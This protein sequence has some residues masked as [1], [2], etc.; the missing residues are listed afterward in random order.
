MNRSKL[1]KRLIELRKHNYQDLDEIELST[2]TNA[3]LKHIGDPD[4]K[5]RDTLIYNS[6]TY[7]IVHD[8]YSDDDLK[9][10][11]E[12]VLT[13]DYL[14]YGLGEKG[15]NSVFTRSFSTLLIALILHVNLKR[16][17]LS[18]NEL[19][20]LSN[21]LLV[22]LERE[23]DVRGL[24]EGSGW[25][26]SIA[27]VADA[28]DELA[29]QQDLTSKELETLLVAIMDKMSFNE[30]YF[31]FE[32]NERMAIPTMT[33]LSRGSD[34]KVLINRIEEVSKDL[35]TNFSSDERSQLIC[36]YCEAI[37]TGF[38][39]SIRSCRAKPRA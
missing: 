9:G 21:L 8:Y 19:R 38:V 28:I 17:F 30:D 23:V 33:I 35:Y 24:I 16:K 2:L 20:R 36:R 37:F 11:L 39:F 3:M 29:K 4:S 1:K 10:L 25:A 18:I 27:H 13:K 5:L 12:N 15:D 22:Y 32:E 6:F 31:L 7:L 26:H 14:F 34:D